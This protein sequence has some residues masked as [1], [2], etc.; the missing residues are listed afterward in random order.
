MIRICPNCSNVDVN[1][2]KTLV[3]EEKCK[4]WLYRSV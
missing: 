3:G 2:L 1:K 4:D